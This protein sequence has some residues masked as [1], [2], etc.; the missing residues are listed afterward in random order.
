MSEERRLKPFAAPYAEDDAT[1]AARLLAQR[2]SASVRATTEALARE[3]VA[4][5]RPQGMLLGGIEDFLREFS[6]TS[7]EGLAVMA[8]AESLLRVPDDAT[9]DRLLAD[10]LAAGDFAHH[11]IAGDAL[12][13][14]ACAFA[15]GLS[16]RLFE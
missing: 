5:S 10:K 11:H 14:Q 16:A 12:L 8:L 7:R 2:P 6:L 13:V 3:L 15:L 9:L 1:I 4:A